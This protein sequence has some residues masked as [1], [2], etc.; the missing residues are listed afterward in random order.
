M[1][2]AIA[3]RT[4]LELIDKFLRSSAGNSRAD[5][6][7]LRLEQ[8][9]ERRPLL[10][11]EILVS[12]Q[13]PLLNMQNIARASGIIGLGGLAFIA[14]TIL[15]VLFG[16]ELG[17]PLKFLTVFCA[18]VSGALAGWIIPGVGNSFLMLL[19]MFSNSSAEIDT[20]REE[21]DFFDEY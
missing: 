2:Q 7:L 18:T 5:D 19:V 4:T 20:D 16:Q 15:L 12:Q 17:N 10:I 8:R 13:A 1:V 11:S 3:T 21:Y 14:T 6:L 9:L